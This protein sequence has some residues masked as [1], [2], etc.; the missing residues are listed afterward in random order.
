M[1]QPWIVIKEQF[2]NR[3][4]VR[5]FI[6]IFDPMIDSEAMITVV[7]NIYQSTIA[8]DQTKEYATHRYLNDG[9]PYIDEIICGH[10]PGIYAARAHN[11][12]ST[13]TGQNG[14]RIEWREPHI[15]VE[16]SIWQI[17]Y[18]EDFFAV[19]LSANNNS[20]LKYDK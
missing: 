1:K 16:D 13:S 14:Y 10:N 20:L 18:W 4:P 17:E 15:S 11:I 5:S 9:S 2:N 12:V 7:E 8:H 6:A 19:F 3:Q